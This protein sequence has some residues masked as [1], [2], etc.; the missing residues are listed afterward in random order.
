M[1][2]RR[3]RQGKERKGPSRRGP[4]GAGRREGEWG[5][6][7]TNEYFEWKIHKTSALMKLIYLLH[8]IYMNNFSRFL[9][10]CTSHLRLPTSMTMFLTRRWSGTEGEGGGGA[11]EVYKNTTETWIRMSEWDK[12]TCEWW[13]S[14]NYDSLGIEYYK[15][16]YYHIYIKNLGPVFF[17]L[18]FF[19]CF[20]L[21]P[22]GTAGKLAQ[23]ENKSHPQLHELF[24][25]RYNS[26]L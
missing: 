17:F 9:F 14:G 20:Y 10:F 6:D 16:M 26:L 15:L 13:L 12:L 2:K 8:T 22:A 24:M 4:G 3:E 1:S 21:W 19:I 5:S 11:G 25:E 18:F 7:W 23:W